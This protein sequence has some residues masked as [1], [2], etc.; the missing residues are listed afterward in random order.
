MIHKPESRESIW[1]L[2]IAPLVWA[3]HFMACYLTNAIWCAKFAT[4]SDPTST[5]RWAIALYTL[6]ALP[7]IAIVGWYGYRRERSRYGRVKPHS[8]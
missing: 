2:A 5:V 4:A 1:L 8:R 3:A 6:I 7:L